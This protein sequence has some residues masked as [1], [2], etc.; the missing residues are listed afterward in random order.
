MFCAAHGADPAPGL[1]REGVVDTAAGGADL[2]GGGVAVHFQQPLPLPRQLIAEQFPKPAEAGV[3]DGAAAQ[4]LGDVPQGVL[5]HTHGVPGV[6][7]PP[8]FLVQEV[9][10]LV[11]DVLVEQAVFLDHSLVPVGPRLHPA[12]LLLQGGQFFLGPPQPQRRVGG[13]AVVGHIEVRQR[14]LQRE[15]VVRSGRHRLRRADRAGVEQVGVILAGFGALYGDP[16]QLPAAAGAAGKLCL[17]QAAF[18]HADGI[19]G[20]VNGGAAAAEVVAGG[21]GIPVVLF[22]LEL[23]IA[24][25]FGVAEEIPKGLRQLVVFLG[26]GLVV[27]LFEEGRTLFVFRRGGNEV[28]VGL[29]VKAFVVC[30]HLV[31]DVAAA[32]E[33]FLKQFFLLGRGIEG[34]LEGLILD[35]GSRLGLVL[36]FSHAAHLRALYAGSREFQKVHIFEKTE[37]F[38]F[39]QIRLIF[40]GNASNK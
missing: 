33:G 9:A 23:G 10:P 32:A 16:G 5:P 11:G 21:K 14:A 18:G 3:V 27:D 6:G 29:E 24:E 38:Y 39:F 26:E 36:L 17:D 28:R 1:G 22:A 4:R 19:F 2:G 13:G 30:Q 25:R 20:D 12:E 37:A 8:G 34:D 15:G 31:P 35:S 40:F 7:D